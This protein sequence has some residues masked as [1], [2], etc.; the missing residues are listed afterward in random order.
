MFRMNSER[1]AT[2]QPDGTNVS[3]L[4][5]RWPEERESVRDSDM[6][7]QKVMKTREQ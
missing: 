7:G 2:I 5:G 6:G 3:A 4:A 1:L